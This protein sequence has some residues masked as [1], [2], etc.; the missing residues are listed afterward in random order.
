MSNSILFV[1]DSG[2]TKTTQL[3]F[4]AKYYHKHNPTKKIRLI[5]A[6]GGEMEPF[7][8]SG[9]ID[10]GIVEVFDISFSKNFLATTRRISEGFWPIKDDIDKDGQ[11]ILTEDD[12][13]RTNWKTANVGMYLVDH[14]S[15]VAS[16]FLSHLSDQKNGAGFKESWT[17]E[18][19]GV[20]I[21]GLQMGHYGI[22]QRE[23]Q[24]FVSR[25]LKRL[26][27]DMLGVAALIDKGEDRKKQTVYGPKIAGSAMTEEVP[28]W[29]GDNFYLDSEIVEVVKNNE[30][31][32]VKKKVAWF[33]DHNDNDTNVKCL[34]KIRL[35]SELVPIFN[36]EYPKGFVELS[37]KRGIMDVLETRDRIIKEYRE[38][39]KVS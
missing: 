1:G 20:T 5:V 32:N 15:G 24:K 36:K 6:G 8:T 29:F 31:F 16:S 28:S 26:P 19:D 17:Y 30:T 25:G 10:E 38:K 35:L 11:L 18:D 3:H 12:K 27:V 34:A 21:I 13:Y 2:S 9:I 22:V 14:L 4:L 7:E 33:R 23:I 39:E 37:Y